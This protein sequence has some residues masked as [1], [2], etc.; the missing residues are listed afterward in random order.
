MSINTQKVSMDFIW[1]MTLGSICYGG[2]LGQERWCLG[3][4]CWAPKPAQ[5]GSVLHLQCFLWDQVCPSWLQVVECCQLRHRTGPGLWEGVEGAH[6]NGAALLLWPMDLLL[7]N[8]VE[9]LLSTSMK[10]SVFGAF[11]LSQCRTP[12]TALPTPCNSHH[13]LQQ[14]KGTSM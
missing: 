8:A 4:S 14:S 5:V 2:Q 9:L 11:A 10:L 7:A 3:W 12:S 1:S 13:G 6:G